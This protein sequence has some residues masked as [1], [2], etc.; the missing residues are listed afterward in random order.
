MERLVHP[1][2]RSARERFVQEHE[3]APAI[4]FEIPLLFE[5]DGAGDFDKVIVVSA[6]EAVQRARVLQRAGMSSG[7]LKAILARQMPD[8]E[9]CARADFIVHTGGDLSTTEDQ[10]RKIIACL[11]IPT[12]G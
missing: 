10:V 4:L 8:T 5:T 11:N 7:R 3:A 2:V 1:A 12:R 9:K 6:P